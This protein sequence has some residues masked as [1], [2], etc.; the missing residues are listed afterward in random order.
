MYGN[1]AAPWDLA[2]WFC[3]SAEGNDW[4][5]TGM[6]TPGV[7]DALENLV[8]EHER[9]ADLASVKAFETQGAALQRD[10]L[11]ERGRETDK[12]TGRQTRTWHGCCGYPFPIK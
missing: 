1:M 2:P 7:D 9:D 6:P 10:N 3:S 12:R 4:G 5:R 8:W 11:R